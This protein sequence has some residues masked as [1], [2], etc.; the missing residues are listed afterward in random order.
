MPVTLL[1]L[2]IGKFP[3]FVRRLG[4]LCVGR[5]AKKRKSLRLRLQQHQLFSRGIFWQCPHCVDESNFP[6]ESIRDSRHPSQKESFNGFSTHQCSSPFFANLSKLGTLATRGIIRCR[7]RALEGV[8]CSLFI[9]PA[10]VVAQKIGDEEKFLSF[11]LRWH[12]RSNWV[13]QQR[14]E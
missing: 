6:W 4:L 12:R 9:L 10:I 3:E 7:I 1:R 2:Q 11:V 14:V 8:G 13:L 5:R